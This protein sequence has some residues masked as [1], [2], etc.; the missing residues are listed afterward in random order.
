MAAIIK[1]PDIGGSTIETTYQAFQDTSATL[2]DRMK[3]GRTSIIH[4]LDSLFHMSF[5]A[6]QPNSRNL[7]SVLALLAPGIRINAYTNVML[8]R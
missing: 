5:R 4:A 3:G 2:P 1:D 8:T 7:L 6:L